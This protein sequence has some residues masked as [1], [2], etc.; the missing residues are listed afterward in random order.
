VP[1]TLVIAND[2]PTAQRD[3]ERLDFST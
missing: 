1:I 2:T 3:D